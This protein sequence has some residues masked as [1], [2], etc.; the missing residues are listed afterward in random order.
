MNPDSKSEDVASYIAL[1][2]DDFSQ[3]GYDL[4]TIYMDRNPTHKQ[5][6]LKKLKVLLAALGLSDKIRVEVRHIPAYS[7]KLN[8]AEYIIHQIRLQIL[9]HM[10]VDTT[11]ASIE[12]EIE[13]YLLAQATSNTTANSKH[14]QP[15]LQIRYSIIEWEG[16]KLR[17]RAG[18]SRSNLA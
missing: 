9:H 8:L 18:L 1:L 16:S 5:K 3:E 12:S 15:Y 14:Y 11:I 7:P 2:C 17:F 13:S 4:L 6:M 10:P